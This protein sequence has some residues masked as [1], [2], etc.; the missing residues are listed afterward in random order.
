MTPSVLVTGGCGFIGSH[1]VRLLLRHRPGWRVMNLDH[2]TYAGNLANLRDVEGHPDYTFVHGDIADAG[3]LDRIIGASG[4]RA[5]VNFAAESHVDR[6]ILDAT[7]FLHTNVVG[8]PRSATG[9][10]LKTT[11]TPSSPSWI[12]R[13]PGASTTS[14][15]ASA[16]PTWRSSAPPAKRSRRRP[17]CGRPTWKR[18]SASCPIVPDTTGSMPWTSPASNPNY[19]GGRAPGLRRGCGR[20]CAG[21]L[22]IGTG[23]RR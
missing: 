3:L 6:S 9:Y 13:N 21:I 23:S 14:A 2:L 8:A 22:P 11:A 10:M 16:A 17:G 19:P 5:V 20:P 7:P 15:P 4:P 1:F 12:G 18:S